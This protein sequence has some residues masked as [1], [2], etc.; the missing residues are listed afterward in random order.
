MTEIGPEEIF[1]ADL[2]EV[3]GYEADCFEVSGG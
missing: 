3:F 1:F 2:G